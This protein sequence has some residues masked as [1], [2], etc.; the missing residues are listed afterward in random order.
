MFI[1][2]TGCAKDLKLDTEYNYSGISFN[3]SKEL[4]DEDLK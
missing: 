3:I 2:F 4:N 1:V